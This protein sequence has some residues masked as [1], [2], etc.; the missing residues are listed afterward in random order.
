MYGVRCRRSRGCVFSLKYHLV[1]CPKYRRKVLLGSVIEDL[2]TLLFQKAAELPVTIEALEV[3]QD[4][5]HLFVSADP[6]VSPQ[7]LANQFKGYT[8][9]LLRLKYPE[10][11]SCLPSLW[12]RSD[13]VGSVGQVSEETVK[14]YIETQKGT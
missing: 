11:R 6:T 9:R 2:K 12:S 7:R 3:V 13:Y 8:S 10:L 14:R 4:H 5:V 1:G